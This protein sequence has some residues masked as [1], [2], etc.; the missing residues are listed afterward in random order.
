MK[1][2]PLLFL[3]S[4]LLLLTSGAQDVRPTPRAPKDEAD[5]R[6]WLENMV[7]HHRYSAEEITAATGMDAAA[8]TEVDPEIRARS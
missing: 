6:F 5:L 7:W 4:F 3:F 1:I 8:V 2:S